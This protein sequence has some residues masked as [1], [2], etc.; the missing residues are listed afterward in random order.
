MSRVGCCMRQGLHALMLGV[1]GSDQLR[2]GGD[3]VLPQLGLRGMGSFSLNVKD[4][5]DIAFMTDGRLAQGW[6]GYE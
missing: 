1:Q 5:A 4:Q 2:G 3:C 6:F